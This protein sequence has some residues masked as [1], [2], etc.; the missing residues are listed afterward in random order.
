MQRQAI[1]AGLGVAAF[2]AMLRIPTLSEP[3]WYYDE[4]IFTTVAWASS[5]GMRLYVDVI[6]LQ[7][8]GIHW[9]SRL[10]LAA[11]AGEH[12][13]VT[14]LAV[15]AMAVGSAVL[16]FALARRWMKIWPAAMAGVLTGFGLSMP[17]FNGNLL[18]VE[19]AALPFFLASLVLAFST[20]SLMCLLS[21]AMLGITLIFRPSFLI[22]SVALL[23][24]LLSYGRK[25]IRLLMAG[26]G[27]VVVL[28]AAAGGLWWQGSL[29]AYLNV[30]APIDHSYLLDANRGTWAPIL[31]RFL[32]F[33][34]A[35]FVSFMRASSNGGRFMALLLPASLAGSTLTP[36]GY[37]HFVHE[38]IPPLALG[39][40][41]V[42][43]RYRVRW[44][45]L[46]AAAVA[47]VVLATGQMTLPEWQTALMT[48][49]PPKLARDNLGWDAGYYLNWFAYASQSQ[50]YSEYSAWFPD[51][52][53]R[54]RELNAIRSPG[55]NLQL[56][57]PQPWLYFESGRLPASPYLSATDVWGQA[58]AK[59]R[60]AMALR[61]G[62]A[63]VVVAVTALSTWQDVLSAGSY[64]PVQ[65]APWPTYQSS[66]PNEV[67]R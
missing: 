22:D 5:K 63:D 42:A 58:V 32:I 65:G 52:A 61:N 38:A 7:P 4:G 54:R 16:T 64:M 30:V 44:L 1:L 35:A 49:Y 39:I 41:M 40:A 23:V 45:S 66:R 34:V 36:K 18:N 27:V 57:G 50:S 29:D 2:S 37:G 62:C 48:G 59:E 26:L 3:R 33:G 12:H 47:L 51:V 46:P 14:Q 43:G 20:R 8:P 60:I 9:L 15:S 13:L 55:N 67:C 10:L 19:L 28:A 17:A 24:P 11:G 21:G 6:D 31:V 53:L 56:I 25:E